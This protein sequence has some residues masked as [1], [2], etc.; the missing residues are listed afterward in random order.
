MSVTPI[1][2]CEGEDPLNNNSTLWYNNYVGHYIKTHI[3]NILSL[4]VMGRQKKRPLLATM[5]N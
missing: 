4:S 2:I 5:A 3:N 1:S